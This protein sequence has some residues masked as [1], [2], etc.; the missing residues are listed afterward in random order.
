M[1]TNYSSDARSRKKAPLAI[2]AIRREEIVEAAVAVLAE[3]GIQNLSLSE[4]ERR[5][6][7]SRGQLTYYFP[8]KEN[9]LL[10]A[11]DRVLRMMYERMGTP[12]GPSP[13]VGC[14]AGGWEWVQHL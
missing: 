2:A 6:G 14:E 10:A 11:F 4:I 12:R 1:E 13:E 3:Q 8:A 9:I 7:M 5:A